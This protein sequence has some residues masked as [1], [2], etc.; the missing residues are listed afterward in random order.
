MES[1]F[2]SADVYEFLKLLVELGE[3]HYI[4]SNHCVFRTADR[5]PVGVKIGHGKDSNK[6]ICLYKEGCK[7]TPGSI[8]LNPFDESLGK[9]PERDWFTNTLSILP[10]CLAVFTMKTIAE[11][12]TSKEKD[13]KFKTAQIIS[14]FVDKVDEKFL[15]ELQK[16]RPL[17][18]GMIFYDNSKHVAQ[19]LVDFWD[20]EFEDKMSS[21]IRKSSLRTMKEMLSLIY[22]SD[23]PH[24]YMHKGELVAC[25]KIDAMSHV[26]IEV[27]TKMAPVVEKLT[28]FDLH[29]KELN[30]HLQHLAAYHKAMQ[31]LATSSTTSAMSTSEIDSKIGDH[32]GV[33]WNVSAPKATSSLG[34]VVVP[35]AVGTP[36]KSFIANAV[37]VGVTVN[38]NFGGGVTK[39]PNFGAGAISN[40]IFGGSGVTSPA[41]Y[42]PGIGNVSPVIPQVTAA[43]MSSMTTAAY[44]SMS[45]GSGFGGGFI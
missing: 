17:D 29:T 13:T 26:L 2:S 22:D 20:D 30:G 5:T 28:K 36:D 38:P 43:D 24:E 42:L 4:D 31:W 16:I 6:M 18:A 11:T 14:K 23:N 35:V 3:V 8:Y 34:N 1:N 27:L 7:P 12:I 25:P 40:A 9:H 44:N 10:G 19:L 21:K 39:N 32:S 45:F 41:T 33:P 37:P 15:N